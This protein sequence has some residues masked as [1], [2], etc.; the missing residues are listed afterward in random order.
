MR[1][2]HIEY[3]IGS[4]WKEQVSIVADTHTLGEGGELSLFL[5]GETIAQFASVISWRFTVP[6]PII[7]PDDL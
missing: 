5:N 4:N 1:T 7:Q 6:D 3:I 2:Y